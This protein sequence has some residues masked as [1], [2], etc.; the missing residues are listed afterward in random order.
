MFHVF[1]FSGYFDHIWQPVVSGEVF[2]GVAFSLEMLAVL[3]EFFI[4][5]VLSCSALGAPGSVVH[6]GGG[7]LFLL[8]PLRYS[9]LTTGVG[10]ANGICF[11]GLRH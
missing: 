4:P 9:A 7:A 6:H 11:S 2:A 8:G 5:C 10:F 3:F 1:L